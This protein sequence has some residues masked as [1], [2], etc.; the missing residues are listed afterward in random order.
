MSER[1][2]PAGPPIT[3]GSAE[4]FYAVSANFDPYLDDEAEQEAAEAPVELPPGLRA[5]MADPE[6]RARFNALSG[7]EAIAL[8]ASSLERQSMTLLRGTFRAYAE[9]FAPV[10]LERSLLLWRAH[11]AETGARSDPLWIGVQNYF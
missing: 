7:A 11:R 1:P 8:F 6:R 4:R 9:S 3:G 2:D 5:L 10:S